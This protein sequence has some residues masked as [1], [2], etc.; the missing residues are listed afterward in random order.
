MPSVI[1]SKGGTGALSVVLAGWF[2]RIP[3]IIHESDTIPGLTNL[4]SKYFAT[5][6]GV[7]FKQTLQY[8]PLKKTA[9]VGNPVRTTL[10]VKHYEQSTAKEG[11]GFKGNIPLV[12]VL[13]G[14]QGSRRINN[15]IEL[16][17][18]Q[19]LLETQI[20]HQTGKA[21]IE[22]VKKLSHVELLSMPKGTI[23]HRYEPVGF[24]EDDL[25]LAYAAADIVVTRAG[26]GALFEI[27][28]FGKPAIVIPLPESGNNHQRVNAYEFAKIGGAIVIEEGN[29]FPGVFL[30]QVKSLLKSYIDLDAMGKASHSFF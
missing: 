12:L 1:F 27:A 20:L 29:L 6:I 16:N 11:L 5:R 25:P 9:L 23:L 30:S 8:F 17:L 18:P 22:E 21:N 24:L 7:S 4:L 14:S 10:V 26:A 28:A 15:F 19:L 13:G 2:Y 3:I